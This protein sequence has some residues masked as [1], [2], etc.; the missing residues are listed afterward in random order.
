[1][2]DSLLVTDLAVRLRPRSPRRECMEPMNA[3][4]GSSGDRPA[5]SSS[6]LS[7]STLIPRRA[8]SFDL[9][10]GANVPGQV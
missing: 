2:D 4:K 3:F 8:A 6:T 5:L 9:V 1:M 7:S 10:G